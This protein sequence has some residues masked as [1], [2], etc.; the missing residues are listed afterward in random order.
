MVGSFSIGASKSIPL[1]SSCPRT[2]AIRGF[3]D[4]DTADDL[5]RI[6]WLLIRRALFRNSAM[7]SSTSTSESADARD[8]MLVRR[9]SALLLRRRRRRG[10]EL[11]GSCVDS[12][13]AIATSLADNHVLKNVTIHVHFF[14]VL[15]S[16]FNNN[17]GDPPNGLSRL[18]HF[19]SH[20]LKLRQLEI[21]LPENGINEVVLRGM[22]H[23]VK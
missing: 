18:R 19:L 2:L 1:N 13:V 14:Q 16:S 11:T 9:L 12:F 21:V 8:S 20:N 5:R 4:G 7:Y 3:E 10:L 23:G 15:S 17:V 22:I 6:R